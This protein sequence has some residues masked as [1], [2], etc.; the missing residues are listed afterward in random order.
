MTY[1]ISQNLKIYYLKMQRLMNFYAK[2]PFLVTSELSIYSLRSC[3][4]P[5]DFFYVVLEVFLVKEPI[6]FPVQELFYTAYIVF[7]EFFFEVSALGMF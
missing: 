4:S 2:F 1:R 5:Y 6:V 7:V 3:S